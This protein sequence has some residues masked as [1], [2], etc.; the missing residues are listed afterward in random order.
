MEMKEK[1]KINYLELM[2]TVCLIFCFLFILKRFF[3]VFCRIFLLKFQILRL[4]N[5]NE[6]PIFVLENIIIKILINLCLLISLIGLQLYSHKIFLF[7]S[8]N[9]IL[10][11]LGMIQNK[12]NETKEA[13]LEVSVFSSSVYLFL[14]CSRINHKFS[15]HHISPHIFTHIQP[16]CNHFN[17]NA[18]RENQPPQPSFVS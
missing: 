16:K 12:K 2:L 4:Y 14:F 15:D 10:V 7:L 6:F 3:Y 8:M 1:G 17:F 11:F 9:I 5:F 13:F 18:R